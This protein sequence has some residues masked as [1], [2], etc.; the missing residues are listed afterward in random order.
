MY[1][2]LAKAL[3]VYRN[4]EGEQGQVYYYRQVKQLE[5]KVD[6]DKQRGK[7]QVMELKPKGRN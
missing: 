7:K 1:I 3:T 5:D 2:C 6:Y 4:L